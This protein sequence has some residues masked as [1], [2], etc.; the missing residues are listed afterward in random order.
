MARRIS[1]A[2]TSEDTAGVFFVDVLRSIVNSKN[3]KSSRIC[4]YKAFAFSLCNN[5]ININLT[6][7]NNVFVFNTHIAYNI[8]STVNYSKS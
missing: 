5:L 1:F 4:S 7:C 8:I 2:L 3:L 6:V